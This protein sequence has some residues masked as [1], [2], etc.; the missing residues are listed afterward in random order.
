MFPDVS[1]LTPVHTC[2]K[3]RAPLKPGDAILQMRVVTGV[4]GGRTFVQDQPEAAHFSCENP[5]ITL[6]EAL[7]IARHTLKLGDPPN[8]PAAAPEYQCL[9]CSKTFT[10]EDRLLLLYRVEGVA[11]DPLHN[12]PAIRCTDGYECAHADCADPK[13]HGA[14]NLILLS[15]A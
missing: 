6:P 13:L 1:D 4:E 5:Q 12:A 7:R 8:V 15:G 11:M 9:R 2:R 3:C 10:R 14:R